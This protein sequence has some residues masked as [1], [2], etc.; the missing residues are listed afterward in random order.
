[1][2]TGIG[3]LLTINVRDFRRFDGGS[4]TS[5]VLDS[6]HKMIF[7]DPT[8]T[9]LLGSIEAD[10]LVLLCGAG[11]S[12][13]APSRLMSAV[14]V[15]RV[16]YDK[17]QSISALPGAM[18]DD[19]DQLAG[20]FYGTGEFESVFIGAL[21]PWND[22]VGE[23]NGGHAA[24]ADFLISGAAVAALSANFDLLIEQWAHRKRVAMRGALDG[25]EAQN[26][27]ASE[28]PLVKFHGCLHI[29]REKTLWTTQQLTDSTIK[30]R[31]DTCSHWMKL[32]LPGKDLLVVG[33]WT[34]WGYLSDI[35]ANAL[36]AGGFNS[37]TVIDPVSA[38]ALQTKAPALWANLTSGITHFEHIQASGSDALA[39]LQTAFSRVWLKKFYALAK[40]FLEAEGKAYAPIDPNLPFEE[41]YDLRRDAEGTPYDRAAHTKQPDGHAASAA[42][43]QTLLLQAHAT[44]HGAWYDYNGKRV[45]VVQ[46]AGENINSVRE[47]YREPP[48]AVQPDVIVCAGALDL[49]VPGHLISSGA[50]SSVVRP[51]PGGGIPWLTLDQARTEFHL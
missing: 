7:D 50:G 40:P 6:W 31:I 30:Q 3:Q 28:R 37:V 47:R 39:E 35:L 49:S 51:A 46:G 34:D 1:M 43:L 23:S 17:Y 32:V 48:A 2:S 41:L 4:K 12:L 8:R 5:V 22:L 11:L 42:F 15:S 27:G 25:R 44:R 38:A 24:V 16:C 10:R 45:R 36:I 33:F 13:P 19:I 14:Q 21:V 26:A 29:D 20:H 18:R 9:R